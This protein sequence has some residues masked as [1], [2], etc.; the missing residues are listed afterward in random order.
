[1]AKKLTITEEYELNTKYNAVNNF[2]YM[3]YKKGII[4]DKVG[5]SLFIFEKKLLK[6]DDPL[7]DIKEVQ[8]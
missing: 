1:M 2:I 8:K 4:T 5:I 7:D 6:K 3:A